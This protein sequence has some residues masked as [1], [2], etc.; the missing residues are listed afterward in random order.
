MIRDEIDALWRP[1]RSNVE[2]SKADTSKAY[3]YKRSLSWGIYITNVVRKNTA[4]G[5]IFRKEERKD[6]NEEGVNRLRIHIYLSRQNVGRFLV[7]WFDLICAVIA[8]HYKRARVSA[9]KRSRSL[10]IEPKLNHNEFHHRGRTGDWR[11]NLIYLLYPSIRSYT[12]FIRCRNIPDS[13]PLQNYSLRINQNRALVHEDEKIFPEKM[14]F[15]EMINLHFAL[16]LR[17]YACVTIS[18]IQTSL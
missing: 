7:T 6:K 18:V 10:A 16:V 5:T 12:S 3:K 11:S 13:S 9:C 17:A 8:L 1:R 4:T 2:S 14:S 15:S